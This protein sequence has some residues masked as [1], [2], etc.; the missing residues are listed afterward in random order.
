M[1]PFT[2]NIY[3]LWLCFLLLLSACM[4]ED[5]QSVPNKGEGVLKLGSPT[6]IAELSSSTQTKAT[7]SLPEGISA[8]DASN[9][10]IAIYDET[11]TKLVKENVNTTDSYVLPV[12]KYMVKVTPTTAS[13][14]ELATTE[15]PAYFEGSTVVE[16]K[17]LQTTT[18]SV[19]VYWGYSILNVT[20]DEELDFHLKDCSLE[21]TIGSETKSFSITNKKLG[22]LY[23]LGGRK[24]TVTF[25]GTN[26]VGSGESVSK[27][28]LSENELP[29]ATQYDITVNASTIEEFDF[30]TATAVHTKDSEGNLNGTDIKLAISSTV[31]KELISSWTATLGE[32]RTYSS[33]TAEDGTMEVTNAWDYVPQGTYTVNYTYTMNEV[34]YSGTTEVTVPAPEFNVFLNAYTSYDKYAGTNGNTKNITEANACDPETL[35]DIKG[36]FTGISQSLIDDEKYGTKTFYIEFN[37][38]KI[39]EFSNTTFWGYSSADLSD[40][41]QTGLDWKA[42]SLVASMT[43]DGTTVTKENTHYITGLPYSISFKDNTSPNGWTFSNKG[44]AFNYISL[45]PVTAFA[46]SMAFYIPVDINVNAILKA[47]AYGGSLPSKYKPKVSIQPASSGEE[48]TVDITL[49]GDVDYPSLATWSEINSG[50]EI[51]TSAKS[52]FCIYISGNKQSGSVAIGN[53]IG[54]VCDNFKV[55]YR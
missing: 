11:G 49:Q 12:G 9:F 10:Q 35:Y 31:P 1:R 28:L 22:P 40:Q 44:E 15:A 27:V 4:Q 19:T 24:T 18:A 54:V 34:Q 14:P 38:S 5:L 13:N 8:P 2:Y 50:N 3:P 21:V 43:F 17:P 45:K 20:V 25:K 30:L 7:A 41:D 46:L 26:Y 37:G 6:V 55:V 47:Y 36:G 48:G 53:D 39:Y 52:K 23:V 42:Y 32:Y 16:I 33:N 51:L 29:R